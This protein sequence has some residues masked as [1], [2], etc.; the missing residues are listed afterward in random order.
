[1]NN[2]FDNALMF[3]NITLLVKTLG[4]KIGELETEAGV[5]P[6]YISRTSKEP[7]AKPGIDFIMNVANALNTSIDTLV[8]VDLSALTPTEHYLI[9]FIEKLKADT[10]LD[11]LNW[12]RES[13]NF[14]KRLEPDFNGNVPH[15]L[16]SYETYLMESECGYPE[17]VE[18]VVFVS[19]S[20]ECNTSIYKDCFNL[21]MKNGAKLYIMNICKDVYRTNDSGALAI[22]LWMHNNKNGAQFLCSN[23]KDTILA[24]IINDLYLTIEE[25]SKHPKIKQ[26]LKN[27]IDAYMQNDF[28]DDPFY[29]DDLPF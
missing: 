4:K 7:F 26:D 12:E 17:A 28:K 15:P 22:E 25:F 24:N 6:G 18:G 11:K 13:K 9:S 10:V 2:S 14:L 27:I 29:D 5:S 19:N 20:F 16:F 3:S 21:R 23:K 1:M 8:G